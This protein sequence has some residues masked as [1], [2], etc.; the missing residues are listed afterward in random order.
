MAKPKKESPTDLFSTAAKTE[1]VF[2]TKKKGKE[3]RKEHAFGEDLDRL[4]AFEIVIAALKGPAEQLK[5]EL[6][7]RAMAFYAAEAVETKNHPASF[8][9]V[10]D[11]ATASAEMRRRGS[12]M[13]VNDP[14]VRTALT[15]AGIV[16]TEQVKI[17]ERFVFNDEF[18]KI[19]TVR[20]A[21]SEAFAAHPVLKPIASQ[22]IKKQ[23]KEFTYIVP[24]NGLDL[25]AQRLDEEQY[26]QLV[27]HLSTFALGKF[28]LDGEAITE[29]KGDEKTVTSAAKAKAVDMLKKMGVF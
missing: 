5:E 24:E 17:P 23:E 10:G 6:K 20:T 25:A 28:Q 18:L 14:D 2:K 22:L 21:I 16:L 13:P 9:A 19:E 1:T 27:P 26:M 15:A 4:A 8:L 29:G 7:E 12:N 11:T 3:D